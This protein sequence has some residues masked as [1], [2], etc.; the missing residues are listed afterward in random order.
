MKTLPSKL[1][2]MKRCSSILVLQF[3]F[4][5][6]YSQTSYQELKEMYFDKD[7]LYVYYHDGKNQ[8]TSITHWKGRKVLGEYDYWKT[9]FFKKIVFK[10]KIL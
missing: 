2:F 9:I 3:L 8:E 1:N 5:P 7:T 4:F 6:L 10:I